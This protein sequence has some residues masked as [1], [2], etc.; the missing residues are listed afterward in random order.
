MPSSASASISA[1]DHRQQLLRIGSDDL[2][3]VELALALRRASRR[4]ATTGRP[5]PGS[6]RA[7]QG[8]FFQPG[9][10]GAHAR[11]VGGAVAL[12]SAVSSSAS[13][14]SPAWRRPRRPFASSRSSLAQRVQDGLDFLLREARAGRHAEL[15][16][17]ILRRVEQHAARRIAG[18][19][20]RG[21]PP[22][23]SSP[24]SRECRHGSPGARRACRCPCRRRWSRTITRSSPRMK[25]SC[26]LFLL[27]GGSPAWKYAGGQALVAQELRPLPRS[28]CGWRNRRWRRPAHPAADRPSASG[29][30]ARTS[31]R[32]WSAPPRNQVGAARAAVEAAQFDAELCRESGPTMSATTSGLAVAVRH[33][34]G[35]TGRVARLSLDEAADIAVVGAEIVAPLRQAMRLVEHPGA[36]LALRQHRAQR[37]GCA[38]ARA[39]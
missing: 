29:G 34:T 4:A 19:A 3:R 35:G 36:D 25:R 32:A 31:R 30:Y 9:D 39:R 8:G 10:G 12:E 20:R 27:S 11:V 14:I 18:R 22:A 28:A 5:A 2:A 24:A 38:A 15:P 33:S 37:R 1:S 23:G 13:R 6:P 16:L 21:R 26:T 7:Q 17:D